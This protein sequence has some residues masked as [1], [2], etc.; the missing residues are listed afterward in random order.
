MT[1]TIKDVAKKAGVS[2]STVS[3]VISGNSRISEET[4]KKVLTIMDELGYHPNMNARSLVVRSTETIGMIMPRSAENVFQNPFFPEVIRGI[5]AAAQENAYSILL[6]AGRDDEEVQRAV[7]KMVQGRQVD[8]VILLNSRI[9]DPIIRY[10]REQDFPFIVIGRP[11]E[12]NAAYVD[13]DNM[14]AA[15]KATS[16]LIQK[17]HRSIAFL[18]GSPE[19]MVTKDRLD[20]YRK[21]LAE[22]GI[23][24]NPD[25]ILHGE[26]LEEGGYEAV[27][28]LL[29]KGK[30]PTAFV[31]TD[32]LMA[33]GVI[34]AL[35]EVGMRVPDDV[36][37]ISFNNVPLARFSSP[38]LTSVDIGI[39]QLGYQAAQKLIEQ[40]RNPSIA[41]SNTLI[42]TRIIERQSVKQI[43]ETNH[44]RRE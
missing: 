36:S 9:R 1:I 3:R 8:G 5:S 25:Y 30:Q 43:A 16:Y 13:N 29:I 44:D 2:P 15:K 18:G 23:P 11:V 12:K 14:E 41:S 39:Y 7:T 40:I 42:A 26:F 24:L 27:K 19:Y 32:D 33:F 22:A 6:S 38:P 20:G 35:A 17:G 4:R 28:Q 34:G 37:I 10:L 31:V 21:A